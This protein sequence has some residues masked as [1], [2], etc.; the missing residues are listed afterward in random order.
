MRYSLIELVL[1]IDPNCEK[2]Q[3]AYQESRNY[4]AIAA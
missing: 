2:I 1:K 4:G 3:V